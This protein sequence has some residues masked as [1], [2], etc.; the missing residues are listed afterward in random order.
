[1]RRSAFISVETVGSDGDAGEITVNARDR[2][3][4]DSTGV[5]GNTPPSAIS[6]RTFRDATGAGGDSTFETAHLQLVNGGRILSSTTEG[7]S[8]NAGQV[9]V[10]ADRIEIRG[11]G[12]A[13][14]AE[15]NTEGDAGNIIILRATELTA[16][17]RGR[18]ST[19]ATDTGAAGNLDIR[20]TRV[21][22]ESGGVLAAETRAGQ[23]NIRIATEH[24]RLRGDSRISTEAS[25]AATGGNITIG[26][27][28][29]AAPLENSVVVLDTSTITA[30]AE[31]GNSGNITIDALV[32]LFP[33]DSIRASAEFV[34]NGEAEPAY[35]RGRIDLASEVGLPELLQGCGAIAGQSRFTH[36]GRGGVAVSP[37]EPPA[38]TSIWEDL[39]IAAPPAPA[40]VE[41]TSWRREGDRVVLAAPPPEAAD[42]QFSAR[43]TEA[44]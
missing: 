38:A 39:A 32:V 25:G 21:T 4:I 36:Y 31:N 13:I 29:P 40:P 15:S 3:R 8:G 6:S 41:A 7:S 30:R 26:P 2:L 23:G 37:E 19:S 14:E 10:R 43:G 33:P 16:S 44:G 11:A 5:G 22:L 1:M 27:L 35:E 42:C 24:L 34:I 20:V 9:T 17:D 12:S 18:I 28:A